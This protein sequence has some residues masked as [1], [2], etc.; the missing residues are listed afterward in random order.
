MTGTVR[1]IWDVTRP[2]FSLK[3]PNLSHKCK[4]DKQY[5]SP[6]GNFTKLK[7]NRYPTELILR[8]KELLFMLNFQHCLNGDLIEK[9]M[10][11][12]LYEYIIL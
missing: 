2:K 7:G 8:D 11:F 5:Y 3:G 1:Y 10:I 12:K 9:N 6:A 4:K